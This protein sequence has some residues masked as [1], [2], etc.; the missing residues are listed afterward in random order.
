ML[1]RMPLERRQAA[2]GVVYY[3][4]PLLR[5]TGIVHAFSTRIGGV[6]CGPFASLNLGSP[7]S[8]LLK[9]DPV[10]IR[11]NRALFAEAVGI[12]GKVLRHVRQV[13]GNHVVRVSA[14]LEWPTDPEADALVSNDSR[15]VL[16]VRVADCAPVLLSTPDGRHVAAIHVG[17]RGVVAR[18]VHQAMCRLREMCG[19]VACQSCL[20]AIGPCIGFEAFEVGPE[21]LGQLRN[22]LTGRLPVRL[23]QSGR[24]HVDLR[25]MV[26]LQLLEAGVRADRIDCDD[27]CT[28]RD[29]DRFFSHRRDGGVTG[30]LGAC[31]S[32]NPPSPCV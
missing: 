11:R 24:A 23:N 12:E 22:V 26:R 30:R 19:Q 13:H 5:G 9:D 2:N 8:G 16:A 1:S 10:N 32:P 27:L 17:W 31:I 28:V 3:A 15:C 7:G 29:A 6:S 14:E 25:E 21:V 18:V 20:A 4:S